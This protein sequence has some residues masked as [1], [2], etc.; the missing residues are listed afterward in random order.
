MRSRSKAGRLKG[1]CTLLR[2]RMY[3]Y[4]TVIGK[5][6]TSELLNKGERR[7]PAERKP[8]RPMRRCR[9]QPSWRDAYI[10]GEKCSPV[11][12]GHERHPSTHRMRGDTAI[13]PLTAPLTA[14]SELEA[15]STLVRQEAA[16]RRVARQRI[17]RITDRDD[18][19]S[20]AAGRH[21]RREQAERRVTL[22]PCRCAVRIK[23]RSGK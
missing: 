20:K 15:V 23:L 2:E 7:E 3:N 13:F 5:S 1:A 6:R 16:Y 17:A 12:L 11:A 21:M 10:P 9:H 22:P 4:S 14:R 19:A 18:H 8:S